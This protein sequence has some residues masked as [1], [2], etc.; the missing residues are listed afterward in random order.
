[1]IGHGNPRAGR[2]STEYALT[3]PAAKRI[4]MSVMTPKVCGSISNESR[5]QNGFVTY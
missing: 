2:P 5:R 3:V 4:A 1:M